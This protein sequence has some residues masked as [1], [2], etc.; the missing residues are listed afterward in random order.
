MKRYICMYSI[1]LP[2]L[3][4]V[5][6]SCTRQ[7]P[8]SGETVRNYLAA[9]ELY[10]SGDLLRAERKLRD[11]T[12]GTPSFYQGRL[13]YAKTLMYREKQAEAETVLLELIE[14]HPCYREAEMLYIRLLL[15]RDDLD[16]AE[17]RINSLL[18]YDS[19][20]PRLLYLKARVSQDRDKTAD[21]L[22][23]LQQAALFREEFA[24]VF[25]DL[26][27]IY[28][29]HGRNGD[30][31]DAVTA[32]LRLLPADSIL[33]RPVRELLIKIRGDNNEQ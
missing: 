25:L 11:F 13:L 6:F 4:T 1:F 29:I 30:A 2:V 17:K 15:G 8:V 9:K 24:G 22:R 33:Y 21:C 10:T 20:D 27:R 5:L 16:G 7:A 18:S 19:T 3:W 28:Y 14:D 12:R 31:D 23:Y 26:G 32:A